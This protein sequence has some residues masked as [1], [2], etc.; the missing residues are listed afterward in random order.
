MSRFVS[1]RI[2]HLLAASFIVAVAECLSD[3]AS[4]GPSNWH[5]T[6]EWPSERVADGDWTP[7]QYY[8]GELAEVTQRARS[9]DGLLPAGKLA[10]IGPASQ[11]VQEAFAN[12][13]NIVVPPPLMLR[14]LSSGRTKQG[15]GSACWQIPSFVPRQNPRNTV[16]Q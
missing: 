1:P 12:P 3:L 8:D 5:Q 2:S 11:R 15:S 14:I 6:Y 10:T 16:T 9:R 7:A 4:N 13:T